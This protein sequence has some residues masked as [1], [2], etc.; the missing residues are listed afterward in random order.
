MTTRCKVGDI[1]MVLHRGRYY[2]RLMKVLA[3]APKGSFMLP[4]GT[5]HEPPGKHPAW[6][7][8]IIGS[9]MECRSANG[10]TSYVTQGVA[11]DSELYPIPRHLL[12]SVKD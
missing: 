2:G 3:E 12:P 10:T 6:V 1:A 11:T 5:K 4:N 9:A 8:D 7:V